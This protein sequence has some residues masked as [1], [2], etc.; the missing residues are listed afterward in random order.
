M[1]DFE[2]LWAEANFDFIWMARYS[3]PSKQALRRVM[4]LLG[5]TCRFMYADRSV[6]GA[7]PYV[8]I[9]FERFE[10]SELAHSI[11]VP[12][13]MDNNSYKEKRE[14]YVS[15]WKQLLQGGKLAIIGTGHKAFSLA[16]WVRAS[17]TEIRF[18][19]Q[20]EDKVGDWSNL[21]IRVYS[22]WDIS[23][24]DPNLIVICIHPKWHMKILEELTEYASSNGYKIP[25]IVDA[26]GCL[27]RDG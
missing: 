5:Y 12:R 23:N 16:D 19:D 8:S 2:A 15:R 10:E 7:E 13:P 26:S 6:V 4:E 22:F 20:S 1:L 14:L 24:F 27:I 11:Q 3:Y 9:I 25:K 17:D 21:G 18:F